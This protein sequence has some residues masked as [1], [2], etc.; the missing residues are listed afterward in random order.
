M[1]NDLADRVD[2]SDIRYGQVW[3]D[4]DVLL[5]GLDV[6]PGG[7]YLSVASAGDNA[8]AL[9]A[10]NPARV[11]AVDLS[12]AQL[13]CLELRVA[14]LRE[15][16]HPQVLELIGSRPSTRRSCLYARCRS[17]LSPATR[18]FWDRRRD[19]IDGG[20]GAAGRLERYFALFRR[21]VLPLIHRQE[22]IEQLLVP[23]DRQR[24]EEFY[25]RRWDTPRWRLLFKTFFSRF[26]MGRLGR[27]PEMLRYAAGPV[28]DRLLERTR[29]ALT[30]LEPARNPYLHWILTGAHREALPVALRP[31][32]FE[33]IRRN[34]DRLEW[35]REPLEDFIRRVQPG[36]FDGFNLSDVFEYVPADEH[37]RTLDDIARAGRPGARL[38]YW[39]LLVPRRSTG[40][41]PSPVRPL[42]ELAARL[43]RTDY[44]F[45]YS[46][47]VLEEVA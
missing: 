19:A 1:A 24:R 18:H 23:R 29:H 3:E 5:D 31:E 41:H 33:T 14:A 15:L 44:G 35:R 2:F 12:Q 39:N 34:L 30:V 37:R 6:R 11:I 16:S 20:I 17:Q 32:S 43:H 13:A 42:S 36:T 26:L 22:R 4:A 25:A 10:R 7:V 21:H 38:A 9:L 45:F 8:L 27:H 28:A 40:A 46:D 47:F